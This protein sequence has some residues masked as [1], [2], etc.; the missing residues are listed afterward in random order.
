MTRIVDAV[1]TRSVQ[2]FEELL[3]GNRPLLLKPVHPQPVLG[4]TRMT[5]WLP[6]RMLKVLRQ[7]LTHVT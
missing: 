5:T 1:I 6:E 7:V 4:V 2:V 3:H